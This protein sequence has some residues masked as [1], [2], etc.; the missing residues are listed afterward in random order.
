MKEKK[1]PFH[2]LHESMESPE[3]EKMEHK[4]KHNMKEITDKAFGKSNIKW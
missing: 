4:G 1:C 3:H 2:K